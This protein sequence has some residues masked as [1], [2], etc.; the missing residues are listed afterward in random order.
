[1]DLVWYYICICQSR[2]LGYWPVS[3]DSHC[4]GEAACYGDP[5]LGGAFE[6]STLR[7]WQW[8][9]KRVSQCALVKAISRIT[10]YEKN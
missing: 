5:Q 1:M 9:Q 4:T 2:R 8:G 6:Q 10:V 3:F 7:S